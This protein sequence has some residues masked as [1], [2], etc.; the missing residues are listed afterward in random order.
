MGNT[1]NNEIVGVLPIDT[2]CTSV[3]ELRGRLRVK[4][5]DFQKGGRVKL[6]RWWYRILTKPSL[7]IP[8]PG[9]GDPGTTMIVRRSRCR[10]ARNN[11]RLTICLR[12]QGGAPTVGV[13]EG[14]SEIPPHP[15]IYYSLSP[16]YYKKITSKKPNTRGTWTERDKLGRIIVHDDEECAQIRANRDAMAL[17][18]QIESQKQRVLQERFAKAEK[19]NDFSGFTFGEKRQYL[20]EQFTIWVE[21]KL[22]PSVIDRYVTKVSQLTGRIFKVEPNSLSSDLVMITDT[23]G[24]ERP[25]RNA[26]MD[27]VEDTIWCA[28]TKLDPEDGLPRVALP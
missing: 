5:F 2:P 7:F 27:G 28:T 16:Q 17:Q 21:Q 10:N 9:T 8:K 18:Q 24:A 4:E 22:L 23:G 13:P 14:C 1:Q 11:Q 15:D 26:L 19:A 3:A 6:N 12:T 25:I 20:Q